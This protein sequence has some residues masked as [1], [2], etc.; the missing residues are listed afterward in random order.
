MSD[1]ETPWTAAHKTPLSV[2]F[3]GQEH[4]S[5][6]PF[7]IPGDLLDPGIKPKSLTSS[8]LADRCF[9]LPLA[10]TGKRTFLPVGQGKK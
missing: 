4:W 3:S 8:A 2:G 7:P 9:F 6:L 10:P 1:S 5:G